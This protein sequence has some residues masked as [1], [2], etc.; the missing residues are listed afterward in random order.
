LGAKGGGGRAGG[1]GMHADAFD[2]DGKKEIHHLK[3]GLKQVLEQ[4][5]PCGQKRGK[6]G[7]GMMKAIQLRLYVCS[8]GKKTCGGRARKEKKREEKKNPPLGKHRGR[9]HTILAVSVNK[10]PR[11][12]LKK[13]Q[14]I[15]DGCKRGGPRH[16]RGGNKIRG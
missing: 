13:I 7:R 14:Q 15:G 8:V 16:N 12:I 2:M 11:P 1:K 6:A 4:A 10:A 3:G 9:H 5:G